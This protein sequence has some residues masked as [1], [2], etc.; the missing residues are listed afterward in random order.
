MEMFKN[1]VFRNGSYSMVLILV[2]IALIV[3]VNVLVGLLPA[4]WLQAD[5]TPNA[6]YSLSE[7][8]ETLLDTL[9]ED[10]TLYLVAETGTEDL[11]LLALLE[12]YAAASK[13]VD[14][15]MKDP[16][17]DPTF[18]NQYTT[19]SGITPNSVI[20]VSAKRG[21]LVDYSS[22]YEVTQ[23]YDAMYNMT[24]TTTFNAEG[25]ITAAIDYVTSDELPMIYQLAGHNELA[26]PDEFAKAAQEQNLSILP[27]MLVTEGR[28]PEDCDVLLLTAPQT[29][30]S[31]EEAQMIL[32]YL[33]QGGHMLAFTD[34]QEGVTLPNLD[35]VLAYYG[36][37]L[38]Q[39][40]VFESD[41]DYHVS[42]YPQYLVPEVKSHA[43]TDP[44]LEN[45]SVV[46]NALMQNIQIGNT[47]SS[48]TVTPLLE[49]TESAYLKSTIAGI[50][51]TDRA[52]GDKV[53]KAVVA[54]AVN[55]PVGDDAEAKLVLISS[56]YML[57][58]QLDS[59]VSGSNMTMF[60]N[61]L[62][63]M[64]E[65][66]QTI[67]IHGKT[68]DTATVFLTAGSATTLT[69]VFTVV[70]PVVVLIVG[71]VIWVRRRKR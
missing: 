60:L 6:I 2:V 50:E 1:R 39:G 47:R 30:F 24:E 42:G 13:H 8:S 31:A 10:V 67:T 56:S 45:N 59:L 22:C 37:K 57:D 29:D 41:P 27:L 51:S 15:V 5:I 32:D 11:T 14:V 4:P 21:L 33:D 53:G 19:T 63:W 43:I 68:M 23:S 69:L 40:L 16:V 18:L 61:A 52:E 36:L 71:L 49:T 66:P 58:A 55:E 12:R 26:L 25:E 20:A 35:S 38:E 28:V 70:L 17:L 54:V 62:G 44:L 48:V 3:A 65:R 34:Y 64:C 7:A 9:D 46:L